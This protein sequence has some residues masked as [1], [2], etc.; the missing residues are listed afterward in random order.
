[1]ITAISRYQKYILL[2]MN[3]RSPNLSVNVSSGLTGSRRCLLTSTCQ[4]LRIVAQYKT[5]LPQTHRLWRVYVAGVDRDSSVGITTRY[6]LDGPE[7]ES[8]FRRDIP[9]PSRPDVGPT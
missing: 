7:I 2:E 8:R 9:H 6:R 5:P 4:G 3:S 1:M